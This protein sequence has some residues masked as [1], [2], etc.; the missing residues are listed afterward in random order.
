MS[1]PTGVSGAVEGP[2]DRLV[3]ERILEARGGVATR[4]QVQ[5]G[6]ANLRRALPGYNAAAA[7]GPWLVLV[8]LDQDFPCAG[9]LVRE[10]LQAPALQMRF[11]VVVRQVE[12]WL[13]A[14]EERF[15]RFFRVRKGLV[16]LAPDALPQP[17]DTL[18]QIVSQSRRRAVR[19]DMMPRPG[20]GRRVGPAYTS[21]L[22]EFIRDQEGG[23]RPEVAARR[24]PSL[25]KC[26]ARVDELLVSKGAVK[27]RR[28]T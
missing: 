16:P 11:R 21:R 2:T 19:E 8:D 12:A 22:D 27:A 4:V 13:L 15:A 3:L 18:V 9:E 1:S 25:A 17:K 7:W 20:S 6:K 26:L 28:K 10:W 24:S 14:D 5:Y 23:W